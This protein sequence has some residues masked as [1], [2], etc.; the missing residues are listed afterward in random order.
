MRSRSPNAAMTGD[1]QKIRPIA[2]PCPALQPLSPLTLIRIKVAPHASS[3]LSSSSLPLQLQLQLLASHLFCN[4]PTTS[5]VS[6]LHLRDMFAFY[7]VT[8]L[9][10]SVGTYFRSPD[11]ATAPDPLPCLQSC[12]LMPHLKIP[13]HLRRSA[14]PSPLPHP[15]PRRA[16]QRM[17]AV[18]T[19]ALSPM[20][21]PLT[22]QPLDY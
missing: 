12:S 17:A 9:L 16:Q 20:Y 2:Q 7:Q 11:S 15:P 8:A 14:S 18:L 6:R 5:F 1:G 22:I 3:S 21:V 4:D 10:S 19:F 13:R